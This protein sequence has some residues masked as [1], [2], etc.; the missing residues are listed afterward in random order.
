MPLNSDLIRKL[1]G[2][3]LEELKRKPCS[4]ARVRAM[5]EAQLRSDYP[6]MSL[7]SSADAFLLLTQEQRASHFHILGTTREGKSK[8]LE[9]LVRHDIRNG[10][11]ATVIDPTA[12]GQT[13]RDILRYCADVGYEKVV[14]ID[15][16]DHLRGEHGNGV[17]PAINPLRVPL[18]PKTGKPYPEAPDAK[19]ESLMDSLRILWGGGDFS[20]TAVITANL[21]DLLTLLIKAGSPLTDAQYF[22]SRGTPW[23][24]AAR[25]QVLDRVYRYDETRESIESIF[26]SKSSY[27]FK[28]EF[29]SSIRRLKPL[30]KYLPGLMYGSTSDTL[31]YAR[32][33]REGYLVLVNLDLV[34]LWGEPQQR[35]LGTFVIA[36]LV[37]A[38]Q[39]LFGAGWRGRHYLYI[40]EAG[41][42][43]SPLLARTM[44]LHGKL[45]LWATI[46][47]QSYEQF[48]D[49][50]VLGTIE[51]T[52]HTKVMFDVPHEADR[53]RMLRDLFSGTITGGMEHWVKT[54]RKQH[55][56]VKIQKNDPIVARIDDV[57]PA[58][59]TDAQVEAF[60]DRIY[61][62]NAF[63]R[64]KA[65]LEAE[66]KHRFA[67]PQGEQVPA[68]AGKPTAAE[69]EPPSKQEEAKREQGED[70]PRAR[71]S[72]LLERE[73]GSDAVLRDKA[74]R[75]R[76]GARKKAP[77]P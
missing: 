40:D 62:S 36:E 1:T 66:I 47:H 29:G 51:T 60:K 20:K 37:A 76:T 42:Y 72:A 10:Y 18:N 56:I 71:G 27:D 8:L 69:P 63:Y 54:L 77:P 31:D 53:T 24:D 3:T 55:A 15:P 6:V 61:A 73:P 49:K 74:R 38:V 12:N 21:T 43:A 46:A 16:H 70:T 14:Y 52:C 30:F 32:L 23:K 19:A 75:Q 9:H 22:T 33:V 2:K 35:A 17:L 25:R 5:A 68:S 50:A 48:E 45:G 67:R 26:A 44:S 11:G 4:V 65:A 13:V 28:S 41:Q 59:S 58:K 34:N 64:T 39:N 57:P 7:G